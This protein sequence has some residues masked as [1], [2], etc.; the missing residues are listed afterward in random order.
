[1][2]RFATPLAIQFVHTFLEYSQTEFSYTKFES[3]ESKQDIKRR[4]SYETEVCL[5]LH[6]RRLTHGA[7]EIKSQCI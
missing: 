7:H 6:G 4:V 3:L 1:M 2:A 5:S